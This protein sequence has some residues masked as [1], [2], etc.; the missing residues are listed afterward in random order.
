M[1]A[2]RHLDGNLANHA[3]ENLRVVTMPTS[4]PQP[5]LSPSTASG[6]VGGAAGGTCAWPRCGEL[7]LC[8]SGYFRNRLVC[9][10]HFDLTNGGGREL[11]VL[12]ADGELLVT[13]RDQLCERLR[14]LSLPHC[15]QCGQPFEG[16]ACGP[17]HAMLAAERAADCPALATVRE[18]REQRNELLKALRSYVEWF[19]AAHEDDCSCDDTCECA[20]KPL[21]DAVNGAI[22]R[23]EGRT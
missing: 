16:P 6:A 19:G 15:S 13:E 14:V 9:R 5:C 21:N 23:A 3:L 22:N 12:R 18:T 2:I 10:D 4:P 7:A 20:C 1:K 17:T 8:E 11:A